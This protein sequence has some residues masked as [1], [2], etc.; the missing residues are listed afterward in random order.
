MDDVQEDS[1]AY[2]SLKVIERQT[3]ASRKIVADLLKF[4]R[5]S[6]STREE[7][8]LNE[9]LADV[10]AVTEHTLGLSNIAIHRQMANDLPGVDGDPEKLRQV[11]VNL[12]NNAHHAMLAQ[13]GGELLLRTRID[14]GDVMVEV[15]DSGHGIPERY[16]ARIFDPFSPPSRSARGRD[17]ASPSPTASSMST[18]ARLKWKARCS[19]SSRGRCPGPSF[20]SGCRAAVPIAGK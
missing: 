15:R 4:S 16:L 6:G 17:S 11:F 20:A 12:V 18:A 9:I 3:K 7:V 19:I 13:G 1:D 2:Q 10:V 8:D 5:Q 14:N